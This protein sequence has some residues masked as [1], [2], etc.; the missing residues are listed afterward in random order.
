MAACVLKIIAVPADPVNPVNQANRSAHGGRYS[1]WYSS[2]CGTINPV[3]FW[4]CRWSRKAASGFMVEGLGLLT[5]LKPFLSQHAQ[6]IGSWTPLKFYQPHS[7]SH[8]I[9]TLG[10]LAAENCR[11]GR[12]DHQRI[13]GCAPQVRE[14]ARSDFKT[15]N[16][17]KKPAQPGGLPTLGLPL[18]RSEWSWENLRMP[19]CVVRHGW[20]W[21]NS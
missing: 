20:D 15:G 19:W 5:A 2:A 11:Y 9:Q 16:R 14:R 12:W 6:E 18:G 1:F 4:R 8:C 7:C 10:R 3:R 13:T 17:F 21:P